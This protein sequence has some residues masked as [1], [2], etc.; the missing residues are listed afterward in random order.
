MSVYSQLHRHITFTHFGMII[1]PD[2]S[3]S[4]KYQF[5]KCILVKVNIY[6]LS[7]TF[8]DKRKIHFTFP[9]G[10]EMAEEYDLQSKELFGN[11][12]FHLKLFAAIC[13]SRNKLK[14]FNGK[15]FNI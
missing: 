6:P 7:C 10:T 3:E 14:L 1:Y 9:D 12:K 2:V 5:L 4:K 15:R 13:F 11:Y 8:S